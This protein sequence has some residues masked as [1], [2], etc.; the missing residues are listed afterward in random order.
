MRMCGWRGPL[1]GLL[2]LRGMAMRILEEGEEG[3]MAVGRNRREQ[4]IL[5]FYGV[6]LKLEVIS[7]L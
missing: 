3:G 5:R 1:L 4:I 2:G 6:V 7:S